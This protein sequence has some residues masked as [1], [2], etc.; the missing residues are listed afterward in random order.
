MPVP[1]SFH[2]DSSL[3]QLQRITGDFFL[4][5]SKYKNGVY[6]IGKKYFDVYTGE[7]NEYHGFYLDP[8]HGT[9]RPWEHP[10]FPGS[11]RFEVYR[12]VYFSTPRSS[13]KVDNGRPFPFWEF[14][15]WDS[16]EGSKPYL[17][18]H[19]GIPRFRTAVCTRTCTGSRVQL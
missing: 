13:S 9:V 8:Y 2:E 16:P 6:Q 11:N 1:K 5:I 10:N 15:Y 3:L 14:L 7:T 19:D 4:G 18:E 12:Y 17:S